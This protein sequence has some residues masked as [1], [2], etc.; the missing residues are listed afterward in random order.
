MR[1]D[2]FT[3][4]MLNILRMSMSIGA[5][6]ISFAVFNGIYKASSGV[7]LLFAVVAQLLIFYVSIYNIV[8]SMKE[9]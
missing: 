7:Y 2:T 6:V 4:T 3:S 8:R 9:L 1:K 5:L